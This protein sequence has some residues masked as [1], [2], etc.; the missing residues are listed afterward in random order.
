M[1]ST[2]PPAASIFFRAPGWGWT[3]YPPLSS[4]DALPGGGAGA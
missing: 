3:R 4:G 1:I 2:E